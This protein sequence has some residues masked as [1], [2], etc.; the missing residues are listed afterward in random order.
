MVHPLRVVLQSIIDLW[1]GDIVG[2]EALLRGPA[3]SHWESP[4]ALFTEAHLQGYHSDLEVQARALALTRFSELLPHQKLFINID[5][6]VLNVPLAVPAHIPPERIVWEISEQHSLLDNPGVFRFIKEC[7][8]AGHTIA[9]DDYG[10]GFMGPGALVAFQPEIIK[11]D[12][13]LIANIHTDRTRQLIVEALVHLGEKMPFS[14][15][16]EGIETV[17]ELICLQ[18]LGIRLG[19]GYLLGRPQETPR[20]HVEPQA[21]AYCRPPHPLSVLT[22]SLRRD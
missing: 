9:L 7:R 13:L 4:W 2:H 20:S 5:T 18:S 15:I 10:A 19:Q 17:E 21:A 1:T 16:A 11:L 22:R 8:S 14:I 3:G 6:T 12:R